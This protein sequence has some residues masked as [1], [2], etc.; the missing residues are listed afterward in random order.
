MESAFF[1]QEVKRVHMTG[2]WQELSLAE[3]RDLDV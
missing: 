3:L 2:D 1:T